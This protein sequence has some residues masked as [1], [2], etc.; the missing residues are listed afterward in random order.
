[1]PKTLQ[2]P[3]AS[4]GIAKI[5]AT[6]EARLRGEYP[7]PDF[8]AVSKPAREAAR[9]FWSQ[10]AWSEYAA[11]PVL[12]QILLK[13]SAE[14]APLEELSAATGILQDEALHTAL[15]VQVAQGLGGYVEDIPDYLH[16]DLQ[17]LSAPSDLPLVVWLVV[18][19]CIG[20]T[21]SRAL[22]QARLRATT[23]PQLKALVART[24]RDENVHVAFGWAAARRAVAA[25]DA[26]EKRDLVPWCVNAL[27]G[28]YEGP[29][30]RLLKGRG[31]GLE[32]RQREKVARAGLGS[33]SPEEEDRAVQ[34][35]VRGFIL[36]GLARMGLA[37]G[38]EAKGL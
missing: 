12:S 18:G 2:L 1:M 30:T 38:R 21:V 36:P 11:L 23:A 5:S 35:C 6:L 8:S 15:S 4:P 9:R 31:Q 19:C 17:S 14:G 29:S 32:R 13:L 7:L 24:L 25:L 26:E 20:E 34:R 28:A 33:C 27:R 37:L 22:I 16:L 3:Q 10:R